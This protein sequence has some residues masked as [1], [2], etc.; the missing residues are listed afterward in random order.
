MPGVELIIVAVVAWLLLGSKGSSDLMRGLG[1]LYA[2]VRQT[3]GDLGRQHDLE[4]ARRE[5]AELRQQ[6]I[7]AIPPQDLSTPPDAYQRYKRDFP[8]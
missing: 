7:E 3:I 5:A 4:Q 8:D 6:H 1:R 2:D